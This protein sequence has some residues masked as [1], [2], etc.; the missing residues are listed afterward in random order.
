[1]G[2]RV[3]PDLVEQIQWAAGLGGRFRL[4]DEGVHGRMDLAYGAHG[5]ELYLSLLEAF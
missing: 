3:G 4:N 5:L 1:V 2:P